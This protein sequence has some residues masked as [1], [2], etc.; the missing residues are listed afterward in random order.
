MFYR[1]PIT[2]FLS[3]NELNP[4]NSHNTSNVIPSGTST[5]NSILKQQQQQHQQHQQ[6][7]QHQ[8]QHQQQQQQQQQL[9]TRPS[10]HLSQSNVV[11]SQNGG[12]NK[13]LKKSESFK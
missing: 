9:P 10:N 3:T 1:T 5:L 8:H 2:G 12:E 7:Q 4:L 11:E 6:Q 13:E